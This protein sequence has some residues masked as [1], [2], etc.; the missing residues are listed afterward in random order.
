MRTLQD[1][2]YYDHGE[3]PGAAFGIAFLRAG[4]EATAADVGTLLHR[5]WDLWQGLG[6]GE[7]P[8]LPDATVPPGGL[9]TLVGYG[10]KVYDLPGAGHPVPQGQGE[11]ARF[12]S[13][14]PQ[15]GGP[16][17][18][19]AG[20]RYAPDVTANAATEDVVVQWVADTELAV[21]RAL[22]E[23][24]REIT[25]ARDAA[26]G[27]APLELAAFYRG[28]GR[29][30]GRSWIGFHDGV[31]NLRSGAER[32]GVVTIEPDNAP[33]PAD[34]WTVG[35]TYL[36]FIRL[37]VDLDV[38]DGIDRR[39]QELLV[40]RDKVTGSPLVA[41]GPDGTPEPHAGCPV[42]GTETVL[43]PGNE[44]FREPPPVTDP[45]LLASHVQRANQ[46]RE[47]A[48]APN[49]LRVYRQGYEYL[50][51]SGTSVSVGLNF[52]SFQDSLSRLLRSLT[53][54]GWLGGTNFGGTPPA[55]PELLGVRAAAVFLV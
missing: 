45:A 49:S 46:H 52:V 3:R 18:R 26:T 30:D 27:E 31:S 12:R 32:A 34:A 16:L 4:A 19:G 36:A 21:H 24:A 35:G 33:L 40:G 6:R 17:L 50:E 38:W 39:T 7:V 53:Q 54:P 25:R 5:L 41:V 11:A 23:T 2:I 1:G 47:P 9:T 37:S 51:T 42:A 48:T 43:D 13:P 15:G 8:G 20:L 28:S 55:S 14:L 44:T 22:V 29:D 10:V